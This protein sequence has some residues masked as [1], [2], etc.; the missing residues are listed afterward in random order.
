LALSEVF[1][2]EGR[3]A[4]WG[5]RLVLHFDVYN[6]R[7]SFQKA[8][9]ALAAAVVAV[10]VLLTFFALKRRPDLIGLALAAT[11]VTAYLGLALAGALSFHYVD[12]L[13][14]RPLAG[15]SPVDAAKAALAVAVLGLG[16]RERQAGGLTGRKK[17]TTIQSKPRGGEYP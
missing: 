1:L 2:V 10:L 17:E 16:L 4:D 8:G 11:A 13:R 9:L 7:Q 12:V 6:F 3:L 14:S 5:R 15:I